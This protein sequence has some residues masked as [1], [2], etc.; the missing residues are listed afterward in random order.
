MKILTVSTWKD[1]YYTLPEEEQI[2][3]MKAAVKNV[4]AV[5]KKLGDRVQFY[6]VPGWGRTV[7]IGEHPDVQEYVQC[8][9]GDSPISLSNVET[10][11][12]NELD[13]KSMKAL[14]AWA[15]SP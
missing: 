14:Q 1:V 5:K 8:L 3:R 12:L 2:R 10:Y 11:L 15:D 7:S 13:E 6:G 4:L 9:Q